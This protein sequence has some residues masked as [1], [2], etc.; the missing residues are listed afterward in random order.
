M[1]VWGYWDMALKD[2]DEPIQIK[3]FI[4][5]VRANLDGDNSI[6]NDALAVWSFNKLPK[7]FWDS[8]KAE[9]KEMGIKWQLFLKILKLHT[10]D[11]IKWALY[12]KM[13]W[14]E[15]VDRVSSTIEQYAK[16]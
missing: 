6:D 16:R 12:D 3:E 15:V 9:L 10:D 2:L 5:K 4:R 7:F 13:S 14:D 8:W 1:W 11:F